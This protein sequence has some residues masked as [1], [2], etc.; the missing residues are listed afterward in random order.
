MSLPAISYLL[1]DTPHTQRITRSCPY[2]AIQKLSSLQSSY[3]L[4]YESLVTFKKNYPNFPKLATF[5]S[6]STKLRALLTVLCYVS[7]STSSTTLKVFSNLYVVGGGPNKRKFIFS[8]SYNGTVKDTTW[9]LCF[10]PQEIKNKYKAPRFDAHGQMWF[11][12]KVFIYIKYFILTILVK[13]V[14]VHCNKMQKSSY[15]TWCRAIIQR[16]GHYPSTN[17][18]YM[19]ILSEADN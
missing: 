13:P 9:R 15:K 8:L 14:V 5:C 19:N 10:H 16:A 11:Q 1:D 2:G 6:L 7:S 12:C 17:P 3:G 4:T 18:S